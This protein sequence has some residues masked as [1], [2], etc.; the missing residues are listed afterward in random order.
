MLY[1]CTYVENLDGTFSWTTAAV[2]GY[3]IF[4]IVQDV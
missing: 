1:V 3:H 4:D 2:D